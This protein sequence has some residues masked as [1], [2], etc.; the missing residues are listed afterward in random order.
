MPFE[1]HPQEN[2]PGVYSSV[3][4]HRDWIDQ[5]TQRHGLHGPLRGGAFCAP[6]G[7]DTYNLAVNLFELRI[8]SVRNNSDFGTGLEL[9][10]YILGC[11]R[12]H[13]K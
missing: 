13:R 12:N 10:P 7:E 8:S 4:A 5:E 2:L 11:I 9:P 1:D 6:G 3:A